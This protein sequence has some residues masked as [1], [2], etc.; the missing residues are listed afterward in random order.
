MWH[1]LNNW[2]E[3]IKDTIAEDWRNGFSGGETFGRGVVYS[4]LE[5]K[6]HT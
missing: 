5:G 2:S 1:W 6:R 3:R 4:K